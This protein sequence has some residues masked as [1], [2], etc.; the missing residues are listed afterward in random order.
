MT[1]TPTQSGRSFGLNEAIQALGY[2]LFA[3]GFHQLSNRLDER[4]RDRAERPVFQGSPPVVECR[5][6]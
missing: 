1:I 4:L 2:R 3:S 6:V 5:A